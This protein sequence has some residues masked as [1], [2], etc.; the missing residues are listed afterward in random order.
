MDEMDDREVRNVE[1]DD[2]AEVA[3]WLSESAPGA[4]AYASESAW[5]DLIRGE[6]TTEAA[7]EASAPEWSDATEAA[8][9]QGIATGPNVRC[10]HVGYYGHLGRKQE[11][12]DP[13]AVPYRWICQLLITYTDSNRNTT[14]ATGTGVLISPKHVLTAAHWIKRATKD[15][16]GQW[17]TDEATKIRVTPG[18]STQDTPLGAV[19]ATQN[20]KIASRWN[21]RAP[22]N[23]Y[24][25]ALIELE[26]AI[27]ETR[28]A[29]LR[30]QPLCYWGSRDCPG[31]TVRFVG[32]TELDQLQGNGGA[33]AGYVN[34]RHHMK[35]YVSR[36]GIS[37]VGHSSTMQM[38]A[39]PWN[40]GS[41]VWINTRGE[42]QLVG[43]MLAS[44]TVLRF[45]KPMCD[46]LRTWIG[47]SICGPQ[48]PAPPRK[49]F[50]EQPWAEID[51]AEPID[52]IDT[53]NAIN[54]I[55][56]SDPADA[57]DPTQHPVVAEYLAAHRGTTD[58]AWSEATMDVA[59]AGSDTGPVRA[60]ILWPA[61]GFP[62]VITPGGASDAESARC[63]T[64]LVLTNKQQLTSE[65]AAA[66]VRCVPWAQR[67]RRHVRERTFAAGDI[68]IHAPKIGFTTPNA[69]Q[70]RLVEFG[71]TGATA[72]RASLATAVTKR[73]EKTLPFLHEI[74][75]SA[76]RSAQLAKGHYQLFWNN[77]LEAEDA[78]SDEMAFL[79]SGYATETARALGPLWASHRQY[80][81]DEYEFDYGSLHRPY[82]STTAPRVRAEILHPLF[83]EPAGM[84]TLKIGHLTDLHVDVRND[85]Y[86]ENVTAK[87]YQLTAKGKTQQLSADEF[88][89]LNTLGQFNNWNKSVRSLYTDAKRDATAILLTGDLI[90]YGRAHWGQ[91][92]AAHLQDNDLYTPDRSWF[93]L[94]HLLASGTAYEKPVYTI[95]GNHDWRINPYPPF[96]IGAPGARN[97]FFKERPFKSTVE[98]EQ[99]LQKWETRHAETGLRAAH[100]DGHGRRFSY[101]AK[102]ESELGLLAESPADAV[103]AIVKMMFQTHSMNVKDTPAQTTVASVEWYLLAI[104]PFFDFA[105]TLPNQHRM[106]MLDWAEQ[107]DV[108]FPIV[109][110]GRE[111]PYMVWQAGAAADP[112]PKAKS[113]LTPLQ[114]DLVSRFFALPG[115]SKTIG[116]HAPPVGPYPDWTDRDMLDGRTKYGKEN[117]AKARGPTD[118]VTTKP[119][120]STEQWYGHPLFA[121]APKNGLKGMTADYGS[122]QTKRDWF[123]EQAGNGA[124]N[125]R[126]VLSGHI[127]RN[128][129][130]VVHQMGNE[131]GPTLAG[132]RIVYRVRTSDVAK[133][134]YPA[135]SRTPQGK[136]GP[137]YVN[138]TCAGPNGNSHPI[139]EVGAKVYPGYARVHLTEDGTIEL[140]QFRKLGDPAAQRA[141]VP[142][143]AEMQLQAI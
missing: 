16:R 134:P 35:Q 113:A 39:H 42:H 115:R 60:R 120:G 82:C 50:V 83:V 19:F 5:I 21:P 75:I 59:E 55:E 130:Y 48:A 116:I 80:L 24:N 47:S 107:E 29:A 1:D 71:G 84:P 132:E 124:S 34:D 12:Y 133:A 45:T 14:M 36:G 46:E 94:S 22:E 73:Y 104:N 25:Y 118:F 109:A 92:A 30:G 65:D 126:V 93:L 127:H 38:A 139:A 99:E 141:A 23:Q 17:V 41:P 18:R 4:S 85:V 114:Q 44:N 63:I 26:S 102:A 27:G 32:P 51:R 3:E 89:L 2:M 91:D 77:A 95:L 72:I 137:L 76:S 110:K 37:G 64:L 28:P 6:A 40:G 125:V 78:P 54:P 68:T 100:G 101:A 52:L 56:S 90:D 62:A 11:V 79:L 96:A 98:D 33:T 81:L 10:G 70:A 20:V 53:F 105:F 86:E 142:G 135:V 8:E 13:T 129:A 143:F 122:F 69:S 112:G 123:I 67:G 128:G 119:D 9:S 87:Q 7:S 31:A 15:D 49:E 66:H 136:R 58:A 43:L 61:L 111:Y 106:L 117:A 88:A 131:T 97:F 140:V 108:L 74:R 138:T 103:S 121:T 57:I